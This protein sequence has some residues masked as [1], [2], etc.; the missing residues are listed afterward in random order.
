MMVSERQ[1]CAITVLQPV[2]VEMFFF[3]H[4]FKWV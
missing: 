3:D 2:L 4:V 1:N